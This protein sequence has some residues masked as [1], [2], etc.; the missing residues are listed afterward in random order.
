[1]LNSIIYFEENCTEIFEKLE[2]DFLRN[3]TNF[4]EYVYGI[5]DE[6][7][8]LERI[9]ELEPN[10]RLTEDAAAAMLKEAVQTSY[11]RGGEQT[12]LAAQVGRQTVKNKIH[13]LEFPADG[14]VMEK[15]KTVDCLYIDTDGDYV[16]LQ[17]REKRGI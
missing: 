3:P 1:M 12:S 8:K 10:Q 7:Y 13:A 2:N 4:A 17:F 14:Y 9:L 15:K 6:L 11:R 5:I 16:A